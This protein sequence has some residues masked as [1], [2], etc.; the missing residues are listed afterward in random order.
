MSAE[1]IET[2]VSFQRVSP[3]GICEVRY[4]TGITHTLAEA[5][6]EVARFSEWLGDHAPAPLLVD[7]GESIGQEAEAR[8]YLTSSDDVK[9]VFCRVALLMR[10]P[11]TRVLAN[12]FLGLRQPKIV[13]KVFSDRDRALSWLQE[14]LHER[15]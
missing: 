9:R 2:K 3:E 14:S 1:W 15:R 12:V 7:L 6:E 11:V 4:K 13:L 10:S 8:E 5:R